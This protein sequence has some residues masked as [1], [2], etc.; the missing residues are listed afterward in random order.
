MA[1]LSNKPKKKVLTIDEKVE[2]VSLP[3]KKCLQ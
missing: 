3:V 2:I 1:N